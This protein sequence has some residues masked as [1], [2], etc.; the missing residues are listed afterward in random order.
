[1]AEPERLALV[2]HGS[3]STAEF[4]LRALG[5]A[6][7]EAGYAPVGLDLRTGE[8]SEVESALDAVVDP[9]VGLIAGISLGAHAA[10]R[11][12]ARRSPDLASHRLDGLW[13][14]L[15]A[16]TGD[17]G[18]VAALSAAAAAEVAAEG[19][20]AALARVRP[21]GWVGAELARA[22]PMYGQDGLIAALRQ[23][24]GSPGPARSDLVSLRVPC[25][26]VG[27]PGDPFHPV[28]VAEEWSRLIP[29]AVLRRPV[30]KAATAD[31][32]ALGRAALS[33]WQEAVSGPR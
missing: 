1:M 26:V 17:P 20:E 12:A 15:P 19:L 25:A 23:T 24:A 16:W 7:R 3:G 30:L 32:V 31:P 28:A 2:L 10:V 14:V 33:A 8:V 13:L 29:R 4:A 21:H 18:P 11:W 27:R 6:L 22:W 9:S 5:P